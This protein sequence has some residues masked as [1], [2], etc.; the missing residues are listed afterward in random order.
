MANYG[1]LMMLYSLRLALVL[2]ED[3]W[4]ADDISTNVCCILTLFA[5]DKQLQKYNN[6]TRV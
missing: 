2:Q 5:C 3:K 1:S 4:L 6:S